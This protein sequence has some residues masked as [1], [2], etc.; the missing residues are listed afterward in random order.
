MDIRRYIIL[1]VDGKQL[2]EC[3]YETLN[4]AIDVAS[5]VPGPPAV[6]ER[7]YAF[8]D[9]DLAWTSTGDNT[10]PPADNIND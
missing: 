1:A 10:W 7:T 9:S 8:E 5:N 6:E 2:T 3:E 4:E